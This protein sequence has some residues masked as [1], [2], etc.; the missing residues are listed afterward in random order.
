MPD[1][2]DV[3][4]GM[5]DKRILQ[6]NLYLRQGKTEEAVKDLQN[7]LLMALNKVQMLLY[8]MIDAE[9]ASQNIRTAKDIADKAG[10]MTALFDLWEYNSFIAPLQ[11]AGS[12]ENAHECIRLL[13]KML[14]A[15][16]APWDMGSSSLFYRIAKASDPKQMLPAILSELEKDSAYAFLQDSDEFKELISEYRARSERF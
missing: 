8:K 7:I 10:R 3:T 14:A 15:M 13:R 6:V 4:C 2:E 11:I 1:K 16:L 5:A 12:E 9:L